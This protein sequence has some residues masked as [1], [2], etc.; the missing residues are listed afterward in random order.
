MQNIPTVLIIDDSPDVRKLSRAVLQQAGFNVLTAEDGD[1]G[2]ELL[3]KIKPSIIFVDF[4][5]PK[6]NGYKFCKIVKSNPKMQDIPIVLLTEDKEDVIKTFQERLGIKHYLSKPFEPEHIVSKVKEVLGISDSLLPE[7]HQTIRELFKDEFKGIIKSAL[8]EVLKETE[9]IKSNNIILSGQIGQIS[10]S[11]VL[12]FVSMSKLSGKLTVVSITSTTEILLKDG[13]IVYTVLNM[14][15]Y[16]KSFTSLLI[17]QKGLDDE[18]IE[19]L[20][21][22]AKSSSLPIE[23]YAVKSGLLTEEES[24]AITKQLI[25][26]AIFHTVG[27]HTGH[28]IFEEIQIP[29]NI[30]SLGISLPAEGIVLDALR[31]LDESRAQQQDNLSTL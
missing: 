5:M 28:Y 21:Q 4:I 6:V 27:I 13:N 18:T 9:L 7:F 29:E 2:L 30:L 25:E 15:G 23:L 17:Q 14:P 31:R 8:Y 12:Q 11:D 19:V 26:D 3:K 10:V 22:S 20:I 16:D 24:Q 1:R